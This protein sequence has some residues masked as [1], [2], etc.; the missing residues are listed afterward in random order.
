MRITKRTNGGRTEK[1]FVRN[2]SRL[3]NFQAKE[4]TLSKKIVSKKIVR[5]FVSRFLSLP[6]STALLALAHSYRI[7]S[8]ELRVS[9]HDRAGKIYSSASLRLVSTAKNFKTP[10]EKMPLSAR[11][12]SVICN[13]VVKN[14]GEG[15]KKLWKEFLLAVSAKRSSGKKNP[16]GKAYKLAAQELTKIHKSL[17]AEF[18][19]ENSLPEF[20]KTK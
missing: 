14:D 4:N 1:N 6:F 10:I 19:E 11:A 8:E 2:F 9:G 16:D 5:P 15:E 18:T 17:Y 7:I 13:A 20:V 12:F 3:P